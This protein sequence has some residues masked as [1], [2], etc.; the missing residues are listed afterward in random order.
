MRFKGHLPRAEEFLLVIGLDTRATNGGSAAYANR[1][2]TSHL[3]HADCIGD[4]I[5]GR[6]GFRREILRS[7][8]ALTV[9]L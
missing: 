3:Q 9:G 8:P 6:V 1:F 5:G 2:I 7:P 4:Y